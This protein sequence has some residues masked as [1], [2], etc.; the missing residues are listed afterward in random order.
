MRVL[1]LYFALLPLSA[2]AAD[3][4]QSQYLLLHIGDEWTMDWSLTTPQGTT[5][6]T[7]RRRVVESIVRDGKTYFKLRT[8]LEGAIRAPEEIEY[9]RKDESGVLYIKEGAKETG[10]QI[11]VPL[12]L[13]VGKHWQ[14]HRDGDIVNASIIGLEKVRVGDKTYENCFHIHCE[15][16]SAGMKED[17]W[18]APAVGCVKCETV[19]TDRVKIA[20]T[21]REFKSGGK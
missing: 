8:W 6:A 1:P 4:D 14:R 12:P 18:E 13:T 5:K 19:T 20:F 2:L 21:L 17:Y 15:D 3:I 7:A 9:L 11:E 16:T 10:E